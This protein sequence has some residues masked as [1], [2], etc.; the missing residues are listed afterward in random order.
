MK[1]PNTDKPNNIDKSKSVCEELY[2]ML[3]KIEKDADTLD[4]D[5]QKMQQKASKLRETVTHLRCTYRMNSIKR[6]LDYVHTYYPRLSQK[7]TVN[8]IAHCLNKMNGNIDGIELELNLT[9]DL[10]EE[11][12]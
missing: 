6:V 3:R 5:A 4:D 9:K 8:Y 2:S 12:K 10:L 7:Q 1:L 11:N